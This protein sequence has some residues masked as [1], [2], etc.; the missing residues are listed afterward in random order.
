MGR[1]G[2]LRREAKKIGLSLRSRGIGR[3]NS[4]KKERIKR[5]KERKRKSCGATWTNDVTLA[6][7]V[8]PERKKSLK[9]KTDKGK[10]GGTTAPIKTE[11]RRKVH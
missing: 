7:H 8:T 6:T 3:R 1:G 9:A 5:Y 10:G 4:K 2:S 11:E